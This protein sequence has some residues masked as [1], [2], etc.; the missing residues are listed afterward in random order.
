MIS[1]FFKITIRSLWRNKGFS[2]INIAGLAIGMAS[3][4]LILLW[5]QHEISFDRFHSKADR[6]HLLYSREDYNGKIDAWPSTSALLAEE[7]KRSFAEVEDAVRY[8]AVYFLV[9]VGDKRF[10][11]GGAF[12][13]SGFLSLF[14]YPLLAG[15]AKRALATGHNIV[16]TEHFAKSL[17]GN[18]DPMGKTVRIDSIDL[19]TVA[20][21]LKDLPSNTELDFGYLLPW[22][23][24][25]KLGWDAGQTWAYSNANTYVLL[26][27][28]ASMDAFDKKIT[29]IT[30]SHIS[31]GEGSKRDVFVQPL[32][33]NH[34]YGKVVNGRLVD[35]RIE[36]VK[37]FILVAVF[38]LLIACI[39]FMN[40]STA[41]SEKRAREVGIRKTIGANRKMLIFQFIGESIFLSFLAFLISVF[42]VELSLN[43]FNT[44]AGTRLEF[45]VSNI[46]FWLYSAGFIVL[47]GLL[48]GS[49][50]AFYLSSFRPERVLKK[51]M[52]SGKALV[53]PRKIM[54]VLQFSFAVILTIC[55]L[56]VER[57]I[58]YAKERDSGYEKEKLVFYFSQGEIDRHFELIREALLR[59]G[60]ANAV[61]RLNSPIT[62]VWST[63]SGFSWPGSSEK[64]KGLNFLEYHADGDF[65]KTIGTKV[66]DGR[67]IDAKSFPSDSNAVLLNESAI[68]AMH[69]K[70]PMGQTL[71]GPDG[72][73]RTIVGIV[74]NFVTESPYDQI[75]P[76]IISAWSGGY[77]AVHF[78]L[79]STISV[80]DALARAEKVFRE[81]NP[82]YP[83][84]YIFADQAY[85]RKFRYEQQQGTLAGL[86]A[87]LAIFISCLGLFGLSTYMAES[88]TKEIGVRKVL[89][90]S[91]SNIAFLLS[92]DFIKLVL[93]AILI[94]SPIAW[95]V[96][97]KWL[98]EFSYRIPLSA[99]LFFTSGILALLI[100]IFTVAGQAIK[101][102]ISNPVKCLRTE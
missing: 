8:R 81:F 37:L 60:A 29:P 65:A 59:T 32:V 73:N 5:V 95:L 22:E 35:G 12:V 15:N 51:A 58:K 46:Y 28:G 84:D 63:I 31:S 66:I 69:L 9:T 13:D 62:R 42:L 74:K 102:A 41:R 55:T 2:F 85:A 19:F 82:Q 56:V 98:G 23:Y 43:G 11:L 18:E 39:N 88:R 7:L 36:M 57:Q 90:A 75:K 10:N 61:T 38:I 52:H 101:A 72:S 91:V 99:W 30:R 92:R 33:R 14:S 44:I 54:V 16:L 6:I 70:D 50:P 94:A 48:A 89:G 64:D 86:F 93:I 87:G 71:R 17:F 40:L 34:L 79:N 97:N 53:T 68:E 20:G 78:K 3:A 21:V 24:M 47:T 83:F 76:A 77:G 100:A 26:R 96:M 80:A 4:M 67:D 25:T 1:N 27:K 45:P 49:Y